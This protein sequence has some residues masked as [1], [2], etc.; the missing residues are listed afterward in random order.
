[1]ITLEA[2]HTFVGTGITI[3]ADMQFY[4]EQDDVSPIYTSSDPNN[5][6]PSYEVLN[7]HVEYKPKTE[8]DLT[9]R[10]EVKNL[11][12]ET[13]ADRATSGNDYDVYY[14]KLL[15]PGRSL[16]LSAKAKF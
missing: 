8:L 9:F 13:Y 2:A 11:L 5:P 10:A 1:M 4:L 15:E 6:L 12:D 16:Y 3:G 14:I 7:A